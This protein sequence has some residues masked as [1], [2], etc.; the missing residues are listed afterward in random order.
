MIIDSF[1]RVTLSGI[2][3]RLEIIRAS[4]GVVVRCFADSQLVSVVPHRSITSARGVLS[5][6]KKIGTPSNPESKAPIICS[7]E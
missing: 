1:E 4:V 6:I 7:V 2:V 5:R 3:F